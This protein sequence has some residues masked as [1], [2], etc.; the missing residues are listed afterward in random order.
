LL[1]G[2]DGKKIAIDG[3]YSFKT[4]T[5]TKV[6]N[7]E[8]EGNNDYYV[9]ASGVL[10]HNCNKVL[11]P[12][13]LGSTG[14]T[15]ANNLIEKLAMEEIKSNPYL[16]K[17]LIKSLKDASGRWNGWS[18]MTNRNAHGIEIHYNALWENGTIKAIDDF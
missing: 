10:V 12:L 2:F 16:G 15:T 17:T 14:R 7:L 11:K 3:I 5:A 18:K 1:F 9:S 4:N 8:V 6:Y 13:G